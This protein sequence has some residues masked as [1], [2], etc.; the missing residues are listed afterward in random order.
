MKKRPNGFLPLGRFFY[1]IGGFIFSFVLSLIFNSNRLEANQEI[2]L[3]TEKLFQ[4]LLKN[5]REATEVYMAF[6]LSMSQVC[7]A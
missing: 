7:S 1:L 6:V 5:A 3:L 2:V 4:L